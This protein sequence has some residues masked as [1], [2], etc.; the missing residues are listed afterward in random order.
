[1]KLANGVTR[2]TR[3]NGRLYLKWRNRE[4]LRDGRVRFVK[5]KATVD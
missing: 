4:R 2:H 1:M 5:K 3:E